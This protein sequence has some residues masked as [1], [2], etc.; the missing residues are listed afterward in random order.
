MDIDSGFSG[1]NTRW[2][3]HVL[4]D[5]FGPASAVS[6]AAPLLVTVFLGANDAALKD[7]HPRQYVPVEE[8]TENTKKIVSH[9]KAASGD[10]AQVL[11]IAP[12]PIDEAARIAF[13]SVKY[14]GQETGVAE[15]TN[16]NTGRYA[17]AAVAVAAELG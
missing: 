7:V 17:A 11:L 8:Y 5:V 10:K 15:R 14:P 4:E 6:A 3:L 2:A 12:P 1:Y 9:I 13:Q 16:V